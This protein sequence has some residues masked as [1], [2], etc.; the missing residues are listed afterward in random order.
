MTDAGVL[1]LAP[2]A[3]LKGSERPSSPKRLGSVE[4]MCII[5]CHFYI[6]FK[7]PL[8]WQPGC[9]YLSL[10]ICPRG[11]KLL[12]FHGKFTKFETLRNTVSMAKREKESCSGNLRICR[13]LEIAHCAK[14]CSKRKNLLEIREVAKKLPS[15]FW[16]ALVKVVQ[17]A[18]IRAV[19]DN[20]KM[21]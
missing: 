17:A 11:K 10:I 9:M 4:C 20:V 13:K 21:R 18:S 16:K 6:F 7:K 2:A 8:I 15:N 1:S 19:A 5:V 14:S 3:A 12:L